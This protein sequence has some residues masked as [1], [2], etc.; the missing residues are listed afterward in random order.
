MLCSYYKKFIKNF[1]KIAKP[2]IK[3]LKKDKE[4]IWGKKQQK[5]FEELKS[6]LV[7]YPILQHP[8]YEKEFLVITDASG[9]GLG[10]ILAQKDE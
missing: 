1:S 2:M 8:N 9:I 7:N 3:L 6:K 10:A 5:S 4:F